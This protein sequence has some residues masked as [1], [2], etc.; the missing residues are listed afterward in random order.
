MKARVSRRLLH[1]WPQPIYRGCHFQPLSLRAT[2]KGWGR[3]WPDLSPWGQTP[4]HLCGPDKWRQPS[5]LSY[6][7]TWL[8]Q[9][10]LSLS[11]FL[12][13]WPVQDLAPP[14]VSAT[15]SSLGSLP[16][17]GNCN[18]G[19]WEMTRAEYCS[20]GTIRALFCSF[21]FICVSTLKF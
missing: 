20:P 5:R 2:G 6:L 12:M 17:G 21:I 9:E 3:L 14:L 13:P 4:C 10:Q 7:V 8:Q 15:S 11:L 19:P 18:Q 16:P 1:L